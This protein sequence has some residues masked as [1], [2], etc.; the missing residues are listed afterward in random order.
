MD[1]IDVHLFGFWFVPVAVITSWL[2]LI[3]TAKKKPCE[4]SIFLSRICIFVAFLNKIIEWNP[5]LQ[6]LKMPVS[7]SSFW[8]FPIT[9]TS[10]FGFLFPVLSKFDIWSGMNSSSSISNPDVRIHQRCFK[11]FNSSTIVNNLLIFFDST[12]IMALSLFG[13][14]QIFALF[15]C[16]LPCSRNIWKY[17]LCFNWYHT[18]LEIFCFCILFFLAVHS[19]AQCPNFPH[20]KHASDFWNSNISPSWILGH[21]WFLVNCLYSPL[22]TLYR[23]STVSESPLILRSTVKITLYS[24][25][26]T[27]K[28]IVIN[29]FTS[30]SLPGPKYW[31]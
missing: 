3:L 28:I 31:F 30:K 2:F 17:D 10:V 29:Y 24:S 19:F 25:V 8:P 6:F 14:F 20:L 5:T 18:C 1:F 4:L 15:L 9:T 13:F 16:F 22:I 7:F 23:S 21:T 12:E 26:A 11:M 27:S